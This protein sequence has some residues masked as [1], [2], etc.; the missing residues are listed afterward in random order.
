MPTERWY[1]WERYEKEGFALLEVDGVLYQTIWKPCTLA[2]RVINDNDEPL[3]VPGVDD[4]LPA[5]TSAVLINGD[6]VGPLDA[7]V[8][9]QL[10]ETYL[11]DNVSTGE[12]PGQAAVVLSDIFLSLDDLSGEVESAEGQGKYILKPPRSTL[13]VEN[14][15]VFRGVPNIVQ[16]AGRAGSNLVLRN[17]GISLT[18]RLC[19]GDRNLDPK[20]PGQWVRCITRGLAEMH[21][22]GVTHHDLTFNNAVVSEDVAT[23]IDLECGPYTGG[24][25]PPEGGVEGYEWDKRGDMYSFGM[26]LWSIENRNM[27]RPFM[28]MYRKHTG[29][30]ADLMTRCV[31]LDPDARPTI[32]EAIAE[33]EGILEG[34]GE[35]S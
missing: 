18:E 11:H 22:R 21:E 27:P 1:Q 26:L 5:G 15:I 24:Y 25:Y 31:S 16:V 28:A 10:R 8:V 34:L 17:A 3:P 6:E 7:K 35:L 33:I 9:E 30:F 12:R 14:L 13:E 32:A 23:I 2:D 20:L 29:T 19:F 4:R